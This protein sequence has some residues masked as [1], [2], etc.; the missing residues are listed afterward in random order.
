[1]NQ[2]VCSKCK[3]PL[4]DPYSIAVGM[5]PECRGGLSRKGWKFPKARWAVRGGQ[6]YF[7]GVDGKVE[8]PVGDLTST[9]LRQAQEN[10]SPRRRGSRHK[11]TGEG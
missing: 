6:T 8:P 10:A 1:M 11:E 2:P 7:L 5:G 9:T 4:R 3:R